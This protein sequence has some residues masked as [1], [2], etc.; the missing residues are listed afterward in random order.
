MA[1]MRIVFVLVIALALGACGKKQSPQSP[2]S[3]QDEQME[4]E[5]EERDLAAPLEEDDPESR[6]ADPQEGGE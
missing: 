5:V 6:S 3:S 1:A 4:R 2:A